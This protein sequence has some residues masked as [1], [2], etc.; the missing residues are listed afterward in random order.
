M[1]ILYKRFKKNQMEKKALFK[2][3]KSNQ[4]KNLL[5]MIISSEF[6]IFTNL[7]KNHY[8]EQRMDACKLVQN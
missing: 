6:G 2:K 4:G 5:L 8:F 1:Y 7:I 3:L